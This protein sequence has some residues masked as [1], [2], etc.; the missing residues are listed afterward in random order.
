MN[1]RTSVTN[2]SPLTALSDSFILPTTTY[3]ENLRSAIVSQPEPPLSPDEEEEGFMIPIALDPSPALP[4]LSPSRRSVAG[5]ETVRM[6]GLSAISGVQNSAQADFHDDFKDLVAGSARSGSR[7]QSAMRSPHIAYQEMGRSPSAEMAD[8]TILRGL[9]DTDTMAS[10]PT[11]PTVS[12][13]QERST[14]SERQFFKLS[15]APKARPTG[16]RTTSRNSGNI[17]TLN[18]ITTDGSKSIPVATATSANSESS[19]STVDLLQALKR[20]NSSRLS[21]LG[22]PSDAV[23]TPDEMQ[24][25]ARADSLTKSVTRKEVPKSS[26]FDIVAE[27]AKKPHRRNASNSSPLILDQFTSGLGKGSSFSADGLPARNSSRQPLTLNDDDGVATPRPPVPLSLGHHRIHD[28]VSSIQSEGQFQARENNN[29]PLPPHNASG[30]LSMDEEMGRIMR[31]EEANPS[32]QG[33]F[34]RVSKAVKHGRSHSDKINVGSPKWPRSARNGSVEINSP[35]IQSP[36]PGD[37]LTQVRSQLKYAQQRVAD[38]EA[39]RLTLQERV[40]GTVDIRQVNTELREKRSTMAFLDTQR[41]FVVRELEVMTDHLS[42]AKESNVPLNVETLQNGALKDFS[43]SL[44]KLKDSLGSQIE[45]LMHKKN[46]LTMEVASLIQVKEKNIQEFENLNAKNT[47]LAELNN[48][49]V[50][51]VHELYKHAKQP[52]TASIPALVSPPS[53]GLGIFANPGRD[54]SFETRST[55]SADHSISQLSGVTEV[56][57]ESNYSAAAK[58][59][60]AKKFNWKKGAKNV[61]KGF[62]GAFG[63]NTQNSSL[64]EEQF[65]EGVPYGSLPANEGSGVSN[66]SLPQRG[67][68]PEPRAQTWNFL[69]AQRAAQQS[70]RPGQMLQAGSSQLSVVALPAESG[71]FFLFSGPVLVS[72]C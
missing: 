12:G 35:L 17:S 59:Q 7:D 14:S 57:R 5:I 54:G 47:Q 43:A 71:E 66:I 6:G 30:D 21:P 52:N 20:R 4:P 33:L 46:E 39:E 41:E 34:R 51:N 32:G 65:T 53:S 70:G 3:S 19:S 23:E 60:P 64:R 8:S 45:E 26:S 31:G 13:L 63:T 69:S 15:E 50:H 67:A 28:S 42:K 58:A 29:T 61:S 22:S 49:L 24:K 27:L 68:G 2:D 9:T 25:R 40:N 36:V 55:T 16:S 56:D 10:R 18:M 1:G 37:E 72:F 38:L 62:K 11:S 48:Q 44:H